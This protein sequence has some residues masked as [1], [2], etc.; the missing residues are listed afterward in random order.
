[1]RTEHAARREVALASRD[2][3]ERG[4]V[5]NH[6]GNVTA[7]VAPG[8]IVATPTGLSKRRL[9]PDQLLVVDE[10]KRVV[11][12]RLRAF[13]E[14]GLHLRVYDRR[15]DVRAVVHAHPPHATA[16][17]VSGHGMRCFLPEAVVSLG[18]EVPLVPFAPPGDAAERALAPY[19]EAYDAVLL[20][21][22]GVMSWGDDV[23]QAYLRMELVEHLAHI[24]WLAERTGGPRPLPEDILP[25]LLRARA[26]AGLGREGRGR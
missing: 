15:S 23:E 1:V 2:L 20:E 7:R 25:E 26:R 11:S 16:R 18:V 24:A 14:L 3:W 13:S 21:G 9:G 12:G 19:V 8:R 17:A 10:Q 5:A 6:D 4:W 22:H